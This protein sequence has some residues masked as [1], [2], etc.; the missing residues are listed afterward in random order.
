DDYHDLVL[1]VSAALGLDADCRAFVYLV[2]RADDLLHLERAD[3]L[4]AAADVVLHPVYEVYVSVLVH[5]AGVAGVEPEIPEV[6]DGL[7]RHLV[8]KVEHD[9][10]RPRPYHYFAYGSP[11]HLFIR[12]G[13]DNLDLVSR[14]FLA[15]GADPERLARAHPRA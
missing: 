9:V 7:L 13:I 11:R 4:A 15:A 12:L 3:V 2:V 8:I 10:G 6:L 14:G 1:G 5:P